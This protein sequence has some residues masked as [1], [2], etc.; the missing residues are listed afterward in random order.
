M[1]RLEVRPESPT[2][3]ALVAALV[4]GAGGC[5]HSYVQVGDDDADASTE[6][7]GEVEAA[8]DHGA[9]GCVDGW[10]DPTTGLCWE[11]SSPS[12]WSTWDDALTY[13]DGLVVGESDDWHLPTVTELRSLIRGCAAT[14]TGGACRADDT[15]R[16]RSC[17]TEAC[18]GC[19]ELSGPGDGGVYWPPG[20]RGTRSS[21]LYW[22]SLLCADCDLWPEPV[23]FAWYVDSGCGSVGVYTRSHTSAVRCVRPGP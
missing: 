23:T 2:R 18:N 21:W 22:S 7:D 8:S 20:V 19:P 6:V 16:N 13:C 1:D 14:E 5:F 9:S 11:N 12:F 15:C 4:I 3:L 10:Y 17:W